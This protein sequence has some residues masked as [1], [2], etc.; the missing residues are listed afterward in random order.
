MPR[1]RRRVSLTATLALALPLALAATLCTA[2]PATAKDRDPDPPPRITPTPRSVADRDDTITVSPTVHLVTGDHPDAP[3]LKLTEKALRDAGAARIERTT[4]AKPPGDGLVVHLDGPGAA[5]ALSGLGIEGPAGLPADGYA[6]GIG[7]TANEDRDTIVLSG[8]DATGT[9]YAAQSLRQLLPHRG[10]PGAEVR[11]TAV[12]DWP[13]TGWRGVIEGFYGTPWSHEA[14]L[15]Q[16]DF[17]GA[18]KMNIYVYS[19]KDDAYLRE[20]WR[21]PYPPDQLAKIKELVD[22]AA[23]NHVEFTY[24]LSP[25]LSVCYSSDEDVKALNDKFQ[26]LWDIGVRTFA[27]PL[28][29]ISYTDWNC[30]ADEEKFG[31]GGGAAGAAQAH[32]LNRVNRDFIKAHE[33]AEPLQMVPTEY[34]DVKPSPY[35][36]ALAEQLDKDVL[37]EWTGIGVIAPTMTV[38]EAKAAREVFGHPILTWDNYP[39]ND[40]IRGRLLLG[41]FNG[42]EQGLPAELAGITAN[43]MVQPYAS[44]LALYTVADYAWNDAAYDPAASYSAA[45]REMSGDDRDTTAALRAFADAGYGSLLNKQQSPELA[46]AIKTFWDGGNPAALAT[47]LRALHDAPATLRD[48]LPDRGFIADADPWL[49]SAEAWGTAGRTAL[50]LVRAAR[51][52]DAA[53][54]WKLRQQLPGQVAKAKSFSY[55][56]IDGTKVQVVLADGVL[57][58][59]VEDALAEHNKSL[60]VPGR[61]KATSTLGTYQDNAVSRMTDGDDATYYWS[62]RAVK[63][64]DAVTLDLHSTRPLKKLQLSMGKPGSEADHIHQGI[65]EYSAD[66]KQ[67]TKL[68]DFSGKAEVEAE[69]P[70]GAEARFVRARATAAQSEWLVIR[71]FTATATDT[72]TVTGGPPAAD[73]SDLARAADGDLDAA[74]TAARAP[75]AGETLTVTPA[76]PRDADKVAVLRPQDAEG[77][78]SVEIRIG[79]KWRALGRLSGPY[80]ELDTGGVRAEAVRITWKGGDAPPRISEVVLR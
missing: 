56:W 18:H 10:S 72:T 33:G 74:Y 17:Y 28:D 25:G 9:Y 50:A 78:A 63:A 21:D 47:R 70:D 76:E 66:G 77:S 80:T 23:A 6:L 30:K 31:T 3:A 20:K 42:R 35:K 44:K 65:L 54:A 46:A 45:L 13:G 12:R 43:P 26:T 34:Y 14:R 15:D 68:A 79:G 58:A 39:V 41:P 73:D 40:Y 55:E 59:F 69:A 38:K 53:K 32:L 49:D 19:P 62:D 51:E 24:A 64:D 61:I 75:E 60:G 57:D 4:T 48:A 71:E 2:L 11:G 52:G 7:R 27:V 29:D 5:T 1:P 37:V 8:V 36:K 67:W 22:R 16:L